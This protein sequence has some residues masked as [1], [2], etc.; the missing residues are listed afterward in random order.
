MSVMLCG[1]GACLQ[2][3]GN[4]VTNEAVSSDLRP[5]ERSLASKR[6]HSP[7]GGVGGGCQPSVRQWVCLSWATPAQLL[8]G[9][10]PQR[11]LRQEQEGPPGY[12]GTRL[13]LGHLS[14]V[15]APRSAAQM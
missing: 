1:P 11:A 7:Q 3:T 10:D 13:A 8:Q 5:R 9:T 12:P 14:C 4:Q 2:I 6:A 15:H